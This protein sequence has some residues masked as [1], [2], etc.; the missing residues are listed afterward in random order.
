MFLEILNYDSN[1][2]IFPFVLR[3]LTRDAT[4][5]VAARVDLRE[6]DVTEVEALAL[7]E[8]LV[9][10]AAGLDV[11]SS[12]SKVSPSGTAGNVKPFFPRVTIAFGI[13]FCPE[14]IRL[15]RRVML[16]VSDAFDF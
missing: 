12:S 7:A 9:E 10:T 5:S 11:S 2:L 16:S 1:L 8:R 14:A 6:D 3:R 13:D 15:L 4:D